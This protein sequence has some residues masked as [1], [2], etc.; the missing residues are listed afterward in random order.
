[1]R[2]DWNYVSFHSLMNWNKEGGDTHIHTN[3]L[4]GWNAVHSIRVGVISSPRAI[5]SCH[6][7]VAIK[8]IH[9]E[10]YKSKSPRRG[11]AI[12][13]NQGK[14][15]SREKNTFIS[16]NWCFIKSILNPHAQSSLNFFRPP[17]SLWILL[18]FHN[19]MWSLA[20]WL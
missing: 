18:T 8:T 6:H 11:T 7:V 1:M 19:I 3:S 16:I 20:V 10:S 15:L 13:G 9:R 14:S 12:I 5:H 17:L 4:T 2:N